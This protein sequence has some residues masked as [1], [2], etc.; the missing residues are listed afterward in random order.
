[1]QHISTTILQITV[2]TS[3]RLEF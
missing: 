3:L 2:G 1:M